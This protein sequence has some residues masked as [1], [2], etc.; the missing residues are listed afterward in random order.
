MPDPACG[1]LHPHPAHPCLLP[2][3]RRA[4]SARSVLRTA[5]SAAA[6]RHPHPAR[7]RRGGQAALDR[8]TRGTAP[9][10]LCG[11]ATLSSWFSTPRPTRVRNADARSRPLTSPDTR[12]CLAR[13]QSRCGGPDRRVE[14]AGGHVRHEGPGS[15]Y[16]R[17]RR[18]AR[19]RRLPAARTLAPPGCGPPQFPAPGDEAPRSAVERAGGRAFAPRTL[20]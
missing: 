7:R 2:G 11:R 4:L 9:L 14:G 3:R 16:P 12:R 18:T 15:T 10:A 5:Q 6:P 20:T 13:E 19:L 1:L 8:G 17:G